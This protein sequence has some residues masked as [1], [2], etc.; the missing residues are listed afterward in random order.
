MIFYLFNFFLF[1][2]RKQSF[3]FGGVGGS[4]I[5]FQLERLNNKTV[6]ALFQDIRTIVHFI[7]LGT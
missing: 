6:K 7:K 3:F 2:I 5:C 4:Q 1:P